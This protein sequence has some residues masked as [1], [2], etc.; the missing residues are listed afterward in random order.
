LGTAFGNV[1]RTMAF[2]ARGA[3]KG[4][5]QVPP[6]EFPHLVPS[7]PAGNASVYAGLSGPVF[8][9]SDLAQSG[10]AALCAGAELLEL[11]VAERIVVGGV[12]PRD[13]IVE[14]VLGPLH[15][16]SAAAAQPRGEGAGLVLLEAR[17][18]VVS[19]DV[20][21]LERRAGSLEP[22]SR[23]EQLPAKSAGEQRVLLGA[24]SPELRAALA[25]SAWAG[26]P[27]LD[28]ATE[29]G[30]HE[31]LGAIALALACELLQ[32][33]VERVLVLSSGPSGYQALLLGRAAAGG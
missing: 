32:G 15:G 2:L 3:Q 16:M 33:D 9:V 1:E 6:A 5:R 12:A 23:L 27:R 19:G 10:E 25:A 29:H 31:A 11:G 24:C 22:G 26:V 18:A 28:L 13:A 7:A 30:Y 4:P 21:L 8:A 14:R 17:A 20:L